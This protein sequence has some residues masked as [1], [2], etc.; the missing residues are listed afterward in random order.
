MLPSRPARAR[1]L[2]ICA[3]ATFARSGSAQ[4]VAAEKKDS[5]STPKMFMSE[6][7][8]ALTLTMNIRQIR[9]DRS[10]TSPYRNATITYADADGKP[11]SVPL[12]V[13]THGIWRLK[14]CEFPPLRLNFSNKTTKHT[15]FHDLEK[16]KF[17]NVCKNNNAYEQYVLREFQLYRIY[18]LLTPASHRARLLRVTYADSASGKEEATRYAFVFE[19]PDQMAARLNGR[20]LKT[21][22]ATPDDIDAAQAAIAYVFEYLIANTDFSFNGLHNGELVMKLDGS[23]LLP[24]AYDFDFSGAVNAPYATVDPRL[25]VKRV[26]DRLFRGYCAFKDDYPAA[27]ALFQSKKDAIY[28]LYRDQIG[29]LMDQGDVRETLEYFDDFYSTIRNPRDVLSTC[30]G[31]R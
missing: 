7:P 21:K 28:A 11:V 31:P 25:S 26:R 15:L 4:A 30:L 23:N 18:Q 13:K 12:K 9:G 1:L 27:F 14:H 17:V 5:V 24:I 3:L 22:G 19:D 6:A 29:K 8:L 20:I 16:P 2:A 10:E